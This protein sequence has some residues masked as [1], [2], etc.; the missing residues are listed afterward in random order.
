MDSIHSHLLDLRA[1]VNN[2]N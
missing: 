2:T 1:T